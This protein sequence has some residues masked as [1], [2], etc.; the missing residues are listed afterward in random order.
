MP[1]TTIVEPSLHPTTTERYS[2]TFLATFLGC[3]QAAAWDLRR[4]RGEE[5]VAPAGLDGHGTLITRLGDEHEARILAR[6]EATSEVATIR[7]PGAED[8]AANAARRFVRV[9]DPDASYFRPP[10]T[11]CGRRP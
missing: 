1:T 7:S 4:R 10:A 2:P 9:V 11:G 5:D 6:L 8:A 3:R